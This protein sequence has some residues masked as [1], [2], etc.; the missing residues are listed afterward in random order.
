M[1]RLTQEKDIL[2]II[3]W[4]GRVKKDR[5]LRH[6]HKRA[7]SLVLQGMWGNLWGNSNRIEKVN[8]GPGCEGMG[9]P[10]WR[11]W[12]FLSCIVLIGRKHTPSPALLNYR[13][14]QYGLLER[15]SL[16]DT[17]TCWLYDLEEGNLSKPWFP[18]VKY[19]N[20]F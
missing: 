6:I 10:R 8:W 19:K 9:L 13:S 4:V 15:V 3:K 17:T 12:A 2:S 16:P 7:A 11:V 20:I 1:T 14:E 5:T 18:F